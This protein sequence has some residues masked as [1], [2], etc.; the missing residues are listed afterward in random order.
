MRSVNNRM[1]LQGLKMSRYEP[2]SRLKTSIGRLI[3]SMGLKWNYSFTVDRNY[4]KTGF[5]IQ[6]RTLFCQ[7]PI[8]NDQFRDFSNLGE[9]NCM[10]DKDITLVSNGKKLYKRTF[11]ISLS[12]ICP[13]PV[14]LYHRD[15]S[16]I[17]LFDTLV[18]W[19]MAGSRGSHRSRGFKILRSHDMLDYPKATDF[20]YY[21]LMSQ[22][23][24]IKIQF[25]LNIS[26][27]Y[28]FLTTEKTFLRLG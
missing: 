1:Y 12:L 13:I 11:H 28:P 14:R 6:K 5:F 2:S 24:A 22:N 25:K 21:P 9:I 18:I 26:P 4:K 10:I 20:L 15:D 16:G 8:K 23:K 27:F 7:F 19:F 17:G 3:Q